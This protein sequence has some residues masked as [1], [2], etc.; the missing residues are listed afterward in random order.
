[1]IYHYQNVDFVREQS[2]TEMMKK[3]EE[4][5]DKVP[6]TV[7]KTSMGKIEMPHE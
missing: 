3:Y 6:H 7:R 5:Y 1:L 4:N 2:K